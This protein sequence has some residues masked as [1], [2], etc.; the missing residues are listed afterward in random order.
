MKK[1]AKLGI[2]L[3]LVCI[4]VG[5]T[6]AAAGAEYLSGLAAHY[7]FEQTLAD[8]TGKFA[9][10]QIIGSR[11]GPVPGEVAPVDA[12]WEIEYRDGQ[13]GSAVRLDGSQGILLPSG[14][15]TGNTY[16]IS[17]WVKP[18][19]ITTFTPTFFGAAAGSSWIS[20]VPAGP[21]GDQTMIWSGENWYDGITEM[22]I[23]TD[24]WSHLVVCVNAGDVRMYV[25]GL[26]RFR[27]ID[28][29]DVFSGVEEA[30]FTLGVNWWDPP[31]VGLIDE[32][33]I[34]ERALSP[35]EVDKLF[36][37]AREVV[38]PN[39]PV[40]REVSVHDPV[41]IK[42]DG[43][44]YTFGSHL[45]SAKSDD[46]IQWQ[47]LSTNVSNRNRIVP[48]ARIEL[49]ESLE[50]A[51][52]DTTWAKGI[53]EL[54]DKFYLYYSV[55]TWG[56][57]RSAIALMTADYIEGP[58]QYQGMIINSG[59]QG[60]A[61][62]Q[63]YNRAIHPNAIDPDLFFDT[64]GRLWM[65]YGS[66]FGGMHILELD[67]ETG[68]PLPDQGYGKRLWGGSQ[69]AME[70]P[71]IEY[72]PETGYYYFFISYGTLAADGGYNIRVARSEN[73]DGP[74]FDPA[75]GDMIRATGASTMLYGAKLVGNFLFAESDI[76]Y[77]S[78]GHNSTYYDK[79]LGKYFIFFHTRFPGRGEYHNQ[80]VH[81]LL[82]NT[83]DWPVMAPH[84]YAGETPSPYLVEDVV[85]EYQYV[86]HGRITSARITN[87]T[88]VLL[89]GDGRVSGA[90]EGTWEFTG[91]Y[92]VTI[93]IG[94]EKYYG[95]FLEQWDSGLR[96]WVMTFSAL[97]NNNEAIWGSQI[98]GVY[99]E[100]QN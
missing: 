46:L 24:E 6:G 70:G 95:V 71:H 92:T 82:M 42:V 33:R 86:N 58:Y 22:T 28:F 68:W 39:P 89:T 15:I 36:R 21:I 91:D 61:P 8:S 40:F 25:N 18:E 65:V 2:V 51:N 11:I 53:I 34:Y 13:I 23:P 85:G 47:Q 99:D 27:G 78:P 16:T 45:A 67:P 88:K 26:E 73:P 56:S 55:S 48:N 100:E 66:Y 77:V 83:E 54:N 79:E 50:W 93:T 64:E 12:E 1:L 20:V 44:Y 35:T 9:A 17:L 41:A 62:G 59:I 57:P 94:D 69:A 96:K 74:Y 43:T 7:S 81:L 3:S 63:S 37:R 19:T 76:G 31:F 49:A 29:P 10:G 80:R 52:T 30:V 98:G 84:R 60:A 87:S 90:V 72:N 5:Y 75:G 32:L 4:L 14:L 38:R 97:S